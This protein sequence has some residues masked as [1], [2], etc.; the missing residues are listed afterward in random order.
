MTRWPGVER[1]LLRDREAWVPVRARPGHCSEF[2]GKT[3]Y[4]LKSVN[5]KEKGAVAKSA[6]HLHPL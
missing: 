6:T 4:S 2:M 5:G 3:I 1:A